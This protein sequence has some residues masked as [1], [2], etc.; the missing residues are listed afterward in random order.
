MHGGAELL[1]CN[2]HERTEED[3]LGTINLVEL[4]KVHLLDLVTREPNIDI[5]DTSPHVSIAFPGSGELTPRS[6]IFRFVEVY[7]LVQ[8]ARVHC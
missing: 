6:S 8:Q 2:D 5:K 1:G 3:V 4:W 7:A